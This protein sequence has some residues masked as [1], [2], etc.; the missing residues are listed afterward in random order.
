MNDWKERW[1]A[2]L[3]RFKVEPRRQRIISGRVVLVQEE[4]ACK[5]KAS[6]GLMG[7]GGIALTRPVL[8]DRECDE[9]LDAEVLAVVD[10]QLANP[11][12]AVRAR[13]EERP[14]NV[15][16]MFICLCLLLDDGCVVIGRCIGGSKM[17]NA[18][19]HYSAADE[20]N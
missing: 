15:Q 9:M 18:E 6:V 16:H 1:G 3:D 8:P 10:V 2:V 4:D 13:V 14:L 7:G 12:T 5:H 19:M 17:G 11:R 20:V